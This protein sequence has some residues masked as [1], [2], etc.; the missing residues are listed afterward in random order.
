M[1]KVDKPVT[2]KAPP[3]FAAPFTTVRLPSELTCAA[4]R[5][6]AKFNWLT[7][8]DPRVTSPVFAVSS[9]FITVSELL[10]SQRL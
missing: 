1:L 8:T 9:P 4:L 6:P 3:K 7:V 5:L 2:F 10:I